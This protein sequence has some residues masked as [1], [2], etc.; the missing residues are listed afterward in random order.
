MNMALKRATGDWICF[1][2]ADDEFATPDAIARLLAASHDPMINY[3]SGQA[4][5]INNDGGVRRIMG[6]RWKWER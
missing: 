2:G 3:V 6:T 1:I 4:A 5:L